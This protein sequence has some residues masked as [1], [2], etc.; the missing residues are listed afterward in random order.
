MVIVD[1]AAGILL[2]IL[3][4]LVIFPILG[5]I[6]DAFLNASYHSPPSPP[7]PPLNGRF[8]AIGVLIGVAALVLL[9]F[10]L[11]LTA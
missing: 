4:L 6:G 1:I 10:I 5:A 8:I 2:A 3:A 9:I 7:P 11:S